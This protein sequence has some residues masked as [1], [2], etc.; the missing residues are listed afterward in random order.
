VLTVLHLAGVVQFQVIVKVLLVVLVHE[1]HPSIPA[2]HGKRLFCSRRS[3][4]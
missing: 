4:S 2:N 1:N 3:F